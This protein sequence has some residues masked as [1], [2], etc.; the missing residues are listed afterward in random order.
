MSRKTRSED[1][2][3]LSQKARRKFEVNRN[4]DTQFVSGTP[5][6]DLGAHLGYFEPMDVDSIKLR[7]LVKPRTSGQKEYLRNLRSR[8]PISLALG[9]AGTGKTFLFCFAA[10]EKLKSGEIERIIITRPALESDEN[11]GFLPGGVD[12]KML[13]F[14][15]PIIDSLTDLVGGKT[16]KMMFEKGVVSIRPFAYMR[17]STFSRAFIIAD[18]MQNATVSQF[19]NLITRIGEGSKIVVGGDPS[20]TD[21]KGAENGLN[22][23]L[24][25]HRHFESILGR[26]Q[27]FNVSVLGEE[28]IVRHEAIKEALSIY[29][30]GHIETLRTARTAN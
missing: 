25:R 2:C 18:E 12:S 11:L 14:I 19:K 26:T 13:P 15:L 30:H 10:I 21:L 27:F 24:K 8:E 23:F 6:G 4:E 3:H 5:S 7:I 16:V 22:D 9:P 28:D 20:Q 29:E 17:G 1:G